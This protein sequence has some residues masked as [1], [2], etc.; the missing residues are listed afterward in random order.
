MM[1]EPPG[2]KEGDELCPIC[3]KSKRSHTPE[4]MLACSQKMRELDDAKNDKTE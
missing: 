1:T 4:E 3:K 2:S